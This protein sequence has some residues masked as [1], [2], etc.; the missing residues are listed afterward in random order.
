MLY[1]VLA[2]I[3][4]LPACPGQESN[5]KSV[6]VLAKTMFAAYDKNGDGELQLTELTAAFMLCDD[7]D[8][9]DGTVTREEYV[10]FQVRQNSELEALA[11]VLYSVYDVNNN[12]RLDTDEYEGF[13]RQMDTIIGVRFTSGLHLHEHL[14]SI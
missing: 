10:N 14:T 13:Y 1:L 12:T 2:L 9:S 5:C 3:A 6:D 8:N 7:A 4:L 11:N